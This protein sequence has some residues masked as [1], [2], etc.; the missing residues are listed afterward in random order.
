MEV[1]L[2]CFQVVSPKVKTLLVMRRLSAVMSAS[3]GMV[4][5]RRVFK[6]RCFGDEVWGV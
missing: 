6:I 4:A 3:S 2:F 1:P 5:K